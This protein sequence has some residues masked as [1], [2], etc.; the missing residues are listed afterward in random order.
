[1]SKS[2]KVMSTLAMLGAMTAPAAVVVPAAAASFDCSKASTPY[3]QAICGRPELSAADDVLAKSFATAIGGLTKEG[4]EAMRASQRVWLDY[5]QRVCTDNATPLTSGSYDDEGASC[6]L[7]KLK[8]RSLVLEASR[9]MGG[10]RFY[11]VSQYRAMPD[12]NEADNPDS[13]WKVSSHEMSYPLLDHDDPLAENFNGF[14][15][16]NWATVAGAGGDAA[17]DASADVMDSAV[18]KQVL[19]SRITLETNSYWYGHGAAHGNGAIRYLH[20]FVPENRALLASDVFAGEGWEKTL[21]TLALA[22]LEQEHG[23]WLQLPDNDE[24]IEKIV[25]DPARW[26]FDDDYGLV[27]QFNQYEVAAYAYGAPTITISWD[28]LE[29]IKADNQDKVRYGN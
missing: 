23:D 6:L 7:E 25:T 1:M 14:M 5:A 3:E 10:H 12:P 9:M 4:T 13:Y 17:E 18:V 28:D 22:R 24:I 21:L 20:Y 15:K 8:A 26:S 27:I 29:A 16:Q 11:I 19:N 2:I